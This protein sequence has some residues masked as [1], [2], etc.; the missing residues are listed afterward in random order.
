M[1]HLIQEYGLFLFFF[2]FILATGTHKTSE[3]T[4]ATYF[5]KRKEEWKQNTYKESDL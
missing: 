1:I 3:K 5:L 4:T 2:R